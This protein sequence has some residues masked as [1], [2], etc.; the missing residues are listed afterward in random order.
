VSKQTTLGEFFVIETA[1]FAGSHRWL[2]ECGKSAWEWVRL[3]IAAIVVP[4]LITC[5]RFTALS[6][7]FRG[8]INVE[9]LVLASTYV[10]WRSRLILICAGAELLFDLFEPV[11]HLYYFSPSD[12]LHSLQYL[13]AQPLHRL[14]L[15][16]TYVVAYIA[17]VTVALRFLAPSKDKKKALRFGVTLGA[18]AMLLCAGDFW[19]GRYSAFGADVREC[20]LNLVRTPGA[21]ALRRI[22]VFTMSSKAISPIAVQSATGRLLAKSERDILKIRA[23]VVLVLVES[24]GD[25]R[26]LAAHNDL[27]GV[28]ARDNLRERYSIERGTVPFKGATIAGE[29]RE[30]CGQAFSGGIE[31]ASDSELRSCIPYR[32]AENGY[33]TIGIHG[34]R[35]GM[36]GRN[37]WYPRIGFAKSIFEPD[38]KRAGLRTCPGGLT[39]TCDADVASWIKPILESSSPEHPLFLHWVTLNSHLPVEPGLSPRTASAC[40]AVSAVL[41]DRGLCAWDGLVQAVHQSVYELALA[42][43][44]RPT[45]FIVVGDHAPPF[46]SSRRRKDFSQTEVPYVTL[47]PRE[48]S[49][50]ES[51][52]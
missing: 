50:A 49:S 31:Y 10:V 32:F 23:N 33:L 36:Y 28:Y 38:L 41:R 46:N 35:P 5:A 15:Y 4:N 19:S 44:N 20:R 34:F 51:R 11:A 42:T 43:S 16:G 18:V 39:G 2:G 22:L 45:V 12:A 52:Y 13:G 48:L 21:S 6:E 8:W 25:M 27:E 7:Y 3:F 26:D 37:G 24:W 9:V 47:F 14:A 1:G 29:A 30:L 40:G 17:L